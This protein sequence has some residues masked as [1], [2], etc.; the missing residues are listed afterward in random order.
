MAISCLQNVLSSELRKNEIE[1]GIVTTENPKFRLLT[2][3]E[4]E[5]HLTEL[6]ERD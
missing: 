2:P 5:F 1:V 6:A 4:L 3:D